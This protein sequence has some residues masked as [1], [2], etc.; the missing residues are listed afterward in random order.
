MSRVIIHMLSTI[1]NAVPCTFWAVVHMCR[2]PTLLSDIRDE[3]RSSTRVGSPLKSPFPNFAAGS[4]SD[5]NN[6][7][8][9]SGPKFPAAPTSLLL[10]S[11]FEV[12]S[13]LRQP[14]LQSVY[15]ETL[16]LYVRVFITRCPER[17]D[18][19]I[20]NWLFPKNKVILVSSD[21]AHLDSTVWNT[22]DG[23]YPLTAFW[24]KRF[25]VRGGV[26]K[27]SPA[28]STAVL[29]NDEDVLASHERKLDTKCSS[30]QTSEIDTKISQV[31]TQWFERILDSL[32]RWI[33]GLSRPPLC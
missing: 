19:R 9:P 24:P 8:S 1:T 13:L 11:A 4:K 3:L 17:S 33:K 26:H 7:D 12:D 27:A 18:L 14:L 28:R 10:H 5:L 25:L 29:H 20:S 16:R 22:A 21:P 32:W 6:R 30:P 2:D 15:G 31:H 23:L